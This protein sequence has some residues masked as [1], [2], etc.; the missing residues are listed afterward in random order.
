MRRSQKIARTFGV[1]GLQYRVW[2]EEEVLKGRDHR[3]DGQEQRTAVF[4]EFLKLGAGEI[5]ALRSIVLGL[6]HDRADTYALRGEGDPAECVREDVGAQTAPGVVPIYCQ[7][8]DDRDRNGAGG[9]APNLAGRCG[10]LDRTGRDAE[11]GHDAIVVA[12]DIGSGEPALVLGR[13]LLQPVVERRLAAIKGG[14][15]MAAEQRNR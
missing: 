3:F 14:E 12:H 10:A 13:A 5:E 2:S 1:T 11:I 7:T 15:I 6:H 8:A 4:R 9:I